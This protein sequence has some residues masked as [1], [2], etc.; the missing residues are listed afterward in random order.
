MILSTTM[1]RR[2]QARTSPWISTIDPTGHE[3]RLGTD[4]G[5][6][7]AAIVLKWLN[8][9]NGNEPYLSSITIACQIQQIRHTCFQASELGRCR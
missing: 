5:R 2:T 4:E 8:N 1:N 9:S 7:Q 3:C 6:E